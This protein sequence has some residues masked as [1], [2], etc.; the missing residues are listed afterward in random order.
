DDRS[1]AR[2]GVSARPH[3][4]PGDAGN[5]A[6]SSET[7][8]RHAKRLETWPSKRSKCE[9]GLIRICNSFGN[10]YNYGMSNGH[11]QSDS[12]NHLEDRPEAR[13]GTHH[14][15]GLN[16]IAP[17]DEVNEM[18]GTAQEAVLVGMADDY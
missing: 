15:P 11:R 1:L 4:E 16:W 9:T 8:P 7:D 5:R 14:H 2:A 6:H 3:R 18:L 10:P 13:V 17:L 12:G